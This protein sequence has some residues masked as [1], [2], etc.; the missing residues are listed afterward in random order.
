LAGISNPKEAVAFILDNKPDLIFLDIQMPG[1]NGFDVIKAL[2]EEHVSPAVI[3]V[4]AYDRFAI[5]AIKLAAFDYLLKP[6]DTKELERC[7]DRYFSVVA[8]EEQA[9]RYVNLLESMN[10]DRK[11]KFS[12]AGGFLMI[13]MNDILYIQADWN[14]AKIYLSKNHAGN[15]N[16]EFGC[17]GKN[18]TRNKVHSHQPFCNC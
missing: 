2:K 1:M 16:H 13:N 8:S 6:I 12:T 10:P 17:C 7:L 18:S 15:T 9:T 4:T 11:V 14:Y 3:F 5:D